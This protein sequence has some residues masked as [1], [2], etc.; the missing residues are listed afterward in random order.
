MNRNVII[1]ALAV[2]LVVLVAIFAF[3][4]VN[5]APDAGPGDVTDDNVAAGTPETGEEAGSNEGATTSP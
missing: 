2:V 1:G 3:T 5:Q 4:G